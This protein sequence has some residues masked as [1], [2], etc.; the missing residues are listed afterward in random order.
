MLKMIVS[1]D[2]YYF[3]GPKNQK[4]YFLDGRFSHFLAAFLL[5]VKIL[6]TL[7]NDTTVNPSLFSSVNTFKDLSV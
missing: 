6:I 1:R 2:E 7:S 4:E 5:I 3:E